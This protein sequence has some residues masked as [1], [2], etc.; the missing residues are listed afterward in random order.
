MVHNGTHP[1]G[2]EQNRDGPLPLGIYD[3]ETAPIGAPFGGLEPAHGPSGVHGPGSGKVDTSNR[4]VAHE[5][6]LAAQSVEAYANWGRQYRQLVVPTDYEGDILPCCVVEIEDE[7]QEKWGSAF[8]WFVKL[9]GGQVRSELQLYVAEL[10]NIG[11]RPLASTA[12]KYYII[13]NI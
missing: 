7:K 11:I 13:I 12:Q 10:G 5:G 4:I 9:M 2:Q 6:L 8:P 3:I 1:G